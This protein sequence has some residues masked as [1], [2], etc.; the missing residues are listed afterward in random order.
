MLERRVVFGFALS[1]R[2]PAEQVARIPGDLK[3]IVEQQPRV[4]FDRAHFQEFSSLGLKF[5]VVYYVLDPDFNLYMDIQQAMNLAI[6]ENFRDRG[7]AFSFPDHL[8][9]LV[10]GHEE[11]R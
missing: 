9:E 10:P 7:I 5:E 2:T 1:Y 3:R 6:L 11:S 8:A 4:R